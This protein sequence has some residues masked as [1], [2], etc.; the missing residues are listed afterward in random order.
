MND[1]NADQ[2][3]NS[4]YPEIRVKQVW[5]NEFQLCYLLIFYSFQRPRNLGGLTSTKELAIETNNNSSSP[6]S[7][8]MENRQSDPPAITNIQSEIQMAMSQMKRKGSGIYLLF[9][10]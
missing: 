9:W 5:V 7:D 6:T 1:K 3:K 2:R 10:K 4:S 8:N